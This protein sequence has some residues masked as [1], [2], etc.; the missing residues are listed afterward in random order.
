MILPY[1]LQCNET[2]KVTLLLAKSNIYHVIIF[3]NMYRKIE[4]MDLRKAKYISYTCSFF[5]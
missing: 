1:V 2:F 4:V 5:T 3:L